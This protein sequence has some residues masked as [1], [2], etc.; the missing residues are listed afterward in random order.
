[1]VF[2]GKGFVRNFDLEQTGCV[3]E[4]I[5]RGSPGFVIEEYKRDREIKK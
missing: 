3:Q 2:G 4:R 5:G 1:M